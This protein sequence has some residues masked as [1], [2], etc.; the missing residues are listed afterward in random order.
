LFGKGTKGLS[1][2]GAILCHECH[3]RMDSEWRKDSDR[4]ELATHRTLNWA[5]SRGFLRFDAGGGPADERLR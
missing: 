5:W 1:L 3:V 4:W 2:C